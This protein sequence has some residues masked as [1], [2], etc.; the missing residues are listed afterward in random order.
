MIGKFFRD[1]AGA[2]AIEYALIGTLISIAILGGSL[3]VG[4]EVRS[5]YQRIAEAPF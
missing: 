5:M 3:M 2:T 1:E 4:D